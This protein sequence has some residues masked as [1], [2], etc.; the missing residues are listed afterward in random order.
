MNKLMVFSLMVLMC[1]SCAKKN[2]TSS[3]VDPVEA[4]VES[5]ITMISGMADEQ[6][7]ASLAY[8]APETRPTV[9]A[10]LLGSQAWAADCT[11]AYY[12]SCISGVKNANYNQCSISGTSRQLTGNV[13]LTYSDMSCGLSS[14]GD[15]V[16]RTYSLKINGPR[17]G[18]VEH[19]SDSQTD[20]RNGSAYG[21]GGRLT[22]TSTGWQLDILGRHTTLK[23]SG[24]ELFDVSIRTLSPLSV[25]G[26]LNRA[27][28]VVQGGQLEVNHNIAKFTTTIT[29]S[30]LQWSAAC[31]HPTSGSLSMSFSGTKTGS[32][33]VTFNG[34]GSA[35]VDQGGQTSTIQLSYCE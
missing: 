7:G 28:R 34:C 29:P 27:S 30:N 35:T 20:Y 22:K 2:E 26:G 21:G 1:V 14:N 10:S 8:R 13:A 23:F 24:R 6:V 31:C 3:D 19:S 11:R 15:T 12:S 25:S 32:A 17:G 4:S 5:G 16:T 18:E 33:S 9:W